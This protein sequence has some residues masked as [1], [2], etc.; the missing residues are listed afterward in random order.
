MGNATET[1]QIPLEV[2]EMYEAKFVP[3]LFAE[4]APHL[5]SLAGIAPGQSVLDVACGTGIVAR[6]VSDLTGA[7]SKV[8]G[9][10]LNE[11][12]LTVAR[13]LRPDLEWRKGD[14]GALPFPDESFDV[15]LCQM[16][17]MFF[18][19]RARAFREMRRVVKASGIVAVVV[20]SGLRAQP[21]YAPF[22][23]MAA[24]HAGPDA[25]SL[26]SAYFVCG[27]LTELTGLVQSAG[28]EVVETRTRLGRVKLDSADEFVVVEVKSTPLGERVSDEVYEK[29][30]HD[31]REVL[32]PFTT[33]SGAVEVPLEG[34]LVAARRTS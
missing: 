14:V 8:V 23:E 29:I 13:R 1:F 10:D 22:V 20:P 9:L 26:L 28:F 21:A 11:A 25:K 32:R 7:R 2:A 33:A 34:H 6:T 27:D 30:R 15:V 17:L 3:A 16:A 18:P 5:V 31:A 12:M 19:D 24:R 4:W